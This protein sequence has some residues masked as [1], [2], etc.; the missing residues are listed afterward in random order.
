MSIISEHISKDKKPSHEESEY[1]SD[2]DS[3]LEEGSITS[4]KDTFLSIQYP[5][6][7]NLPTPYVCN[8][9]FGDPDKALRYIMK[10]FNEALQ[11]KYALDM[12]IIL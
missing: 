2:S 7:P 5:S 1:Y 10:N 3:E 12:K 4:E 6:L 9:D 11:S 8:Q